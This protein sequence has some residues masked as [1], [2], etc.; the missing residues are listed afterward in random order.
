MKIISDFANA[1]LI[2]GVCAASICF[3]EMLEGGYS[4][5][6]SLPVRHGDMAANTYYAGDVVARYAA[7]PAD[8]HEPQ[9]L[10]AAQSGFSKWMHHIG[11]DLAASHTDGFKFA[12]VAK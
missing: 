3:V 12:G 11:A 9:H 4:Q 7:Q 10:I 5:P 8:D 6:D 2:F 1:F